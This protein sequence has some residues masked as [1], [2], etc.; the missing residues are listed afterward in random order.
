MVGYPTHALMLANPRAWN[1]TP[2]HSDNTGAHPFPC[3]SR[4][5]EQGRSTATLCT[6]RLHGISEPAVLISQSR[7]HETERPTM[8]RD[9]HLSTTAEAV[10]EPFVPA[11]EDR[12]LSFGAALVGF[13]LTTGLMS[14][15][16]VLLRA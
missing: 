6:V 9:V 16:M 11:P 15:V 5:G 4:R 7:A 3:R 10:A 14:T 12:L 8:T 2:A 13:V 1:G